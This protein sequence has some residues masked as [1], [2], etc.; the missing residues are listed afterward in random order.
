MSAG[1]TMSEMKSALT[2]AID[3]TSQDIADDVAYC[4]FLE[5]KN[6]PKK[7]LKERIWGTL[8]PDFL[9]NAANILIDAGIYYENEEF[10]SP[11]GGEK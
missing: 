1:Y 11:P 7:M 8:N 3:H 4:L 10:H 5:G 2:E 9:E 6:F